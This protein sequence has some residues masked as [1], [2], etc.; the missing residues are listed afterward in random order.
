M[1]VEI[2]KNYLDAILHY[3][4]IYQ[5]NKPSFKLLSLFSICWSTVYANN[6]H[7]IIE[8]IK[9]INSSIIC[10]T[11]IGK[12]C[13]KHYHWRCQS[14]HFENNF[15]KLIFALQLFSSSVHFNGQTKTNRYPCYWFISWSFRSNGTQNAMKIKPETRCV[16]VAILK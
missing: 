5:M 12:E 2:E 4:Q 3:I 7:N 15:C 8:T 16:A 1:P 13:N 9:Q 6:K 11:L 14:T 10:L